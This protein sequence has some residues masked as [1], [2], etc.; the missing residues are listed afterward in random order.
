[1]IK[2]VTRTNLMKED[3]N[4]CITLKCDYDDKIKKV[5]HDDGKGNYAIELDM[6][7][8]ILPYLADENDIAFNNESNN[9]FPPFKASLIFKMDEN[10]IYLGDVRDN[11]FKS[12]RSSNML[13]NSLDGYYLKLS[14]DGKFVVF[15]EKD[16]MKDMSTNF[17]GNFF[18]LS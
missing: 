15:D 12:L 16:K 17:T 2:I 18:H 8:T 1:M 10:R 3:R 11:N 6:K 4:G 9:S 14:R 13:G 7:P 5:L